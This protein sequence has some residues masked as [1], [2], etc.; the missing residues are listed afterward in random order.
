MRKAYVFFVLITALL[1]VFIIVTRKGQNILI[2]S[3]T[4]KTSKAI[5]TAEP[6]ATPKLKVIRE[7]PMLLVAYF[8]NLDEKP[9]VA[10]ILK[11]GEITGCFVGTEFG[12][13]KH[14]TI[15]DINGKEYSF[16]VSDKLDSDLLAKFEKN[17][18]YINKRIKLSWVRALI[19]IRQAGGDYDTMIAI[20]IVVL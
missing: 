15:K 17:P 11:E 19:N 7:E 16:F 2:P 12:D 3:V 9:S 4:S 10:K 14:L 8:Y 20:K 6:I 5:E 13:Y 18:D 1:L